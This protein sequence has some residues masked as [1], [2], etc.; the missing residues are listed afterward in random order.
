MAKELSYTLKVNG[1]DTTIKTFSEFEEK[2]KSLKDKLENQPIN[3]KAY[4]DTQAEVKKL[5]KSYVDAQQRSEGFLTSLSKAPGVLGGL[6]Q[7]I[8][9]AQS[10][11]SSFNMA[12]KTSVFG[13]IATL[14]AQL[15]QK[16]SQMEGVM[17]PLNKIFAIWSNTVGKL[18][19]VILKPLVFILDGVALGL[20]KVTNVITGLIGGSDE[21]ATGVV[22]MTEALDQLDDSTAAF[23]L[24]QAKA[25]RQLQEAREIAGDATVPIEKRK[26]A[27]LDAEKIEEQVAEKNK[28]RQL[29]YAR[30]AAEQIA[31]D[32][33]LSEA[34]IKEIRKYDAA[35]LESFAIEAAE[36]KS[37]NQEKLNSL[38]GYVAKVE[39]IGAEQAKIGKKTQT[40]L[41][42]LDT[43]AASDA[44][45]K[46][47]AA[48]AAADK[49]RQQ[50]IA[51]LDAQIEL[52]KRKDN[53]DLVRLKELQDKK[54]AL[55]EKGQKKTAAQLEL[56]REQQKEAN[57]K[58]GESDIK[59]VQDTEQKKYETQLATLQKGFDE[60]EKLK[61]QNAIKEDQELI[62]QLNAGTL[63]I[64]QYNEKKKQKEE[65]AAKDRLANLESQQAQE[66]N[67]LKEFEGKI[68]PEEYLKRKLDIEKNYGNQIL[69]VQEQLNGQ[70][71]KSTQDAI[72][73]KE[74]AEKD[75][76]EKRIKD[77]ESDLEIQEALGQNLLEGTKAFYENRINVINAAAA[78]EKEKR[79]QAMAEEL[80]AVENDEEAKKQIRDRYNTLDVE[81]SKKTADQIKQTQQDRTR[82]TLQAVSATIDA[83]K[84]L[85]DVLASALDEEAKTS[86]EAFEKRK[87]YQI[88]S[89]IMT[90]ASGII[91][92]LAAPSVIPS[93][94]DWIVKGIN[95][96]ALIAATAININKIKKQ[97]FEAPTGDSGG[98]AATPAVGSTFANG[99]LLDGPSHA[100]G[101]I[102]TRFGELEGG[103]Y[104][105]NKR[106]TESFLPLLTA[107]N[108]AGNRKYE[109]GGMVATMDA[110]QGIMAAQ[111][112]PIIKTY[113]VA[114]DMTS[115]QEADKKL[116]DL[117]KI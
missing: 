54:L 62:K 82:A 75:A 21:A 8:K 30:L 12:L 28:Q 18:A 71:V 109:Q 117:A 27:L 5:E 37:L 74:D 70:S 86:K 112:N 69:Q 76:R 80:K 16:F 26:Q 67:K 100:Q 4:K 59:K 52:E 14:A 77:L 23:E 66:L 1:V 36:F 111:Q 113:V 91:N 105:I 57:T 72:K 47:D 56:F 42:A 95:A 104:V 33:G 43:Q 94:F 6:G 11:F 13:L 96:A 35:A 50:Q 20:E 79:D 116:M 98:A 34:R 106:S 53:T 102:K 31:R 99:G 103:E 40:Q 83:V 90:G 88:A 46:A 48:K 73:K 10:I 110:L 25:N 65:Q 2:I 87:K 7:S 115:Q 68:S 78:L 49:V 39:E 63:T 89:A 107:I 84:G 45:S 93:P 64:D 22:E 3:S 108:S 38:Y 81:A 17:E 9:G 24:T 32:Q 15:I 41:K 101:G 92:I 58:E 85:T 19:N 61:R 114:S 97:Q 55:E 60:A 29:A 51:D 44:K